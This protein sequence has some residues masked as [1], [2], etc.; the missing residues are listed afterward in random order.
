KAATVEAE[1]QSVGV[2]EIEGFLRYPNFRKLS[3][4]YFSGRTCVHARRLL[5]LRLLISVGEL[6]SMLEGCCC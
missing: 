3:T 4:S 6:A 5:L 1:R 2:P